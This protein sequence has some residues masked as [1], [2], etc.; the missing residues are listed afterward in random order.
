MAIKIPYL[1]ILNISLLTTSLALIAIS[2]LTIVWTDRVLDHDFSTRVTQWYRGYA[3]SP[4]Q[5]YIVTVTFDDIQENLIFAAS[6][7]TLFAGL[8]AI[9]GHFEVYRVGAALRKSM[10]M[11]VDEAN[12]YIYQSSKPSTI[13]KT[14]LLHFAPGLA[15]VF[16][17]VAIIA[18]SAR[19]AALARDT[20]FWENG[21]IAGY[22]FQCTKELGV[23]RVLGYTVGGWTPQM[24]LW[25]TCMELHR[26]R[27][28]LIPLTV[29]SAV[30]FGLGVAR[31]V[32]MG[33]K[34]EDKWAEERV[35][36]LQAGQE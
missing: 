28:M 35:Q 31:M 3:S 27:T 18:T 23:C 16:S 19:H 4:E 29:V 36:V 7:L 6:A 22:R 17:L 15:F 20:C 8:A 2:I 26:A 5:K 34:G 9:V 32:V 30:V 1:T 13:L 25:E 33:R 11:N 14:T 24:P 21:W 10:E 12:Y